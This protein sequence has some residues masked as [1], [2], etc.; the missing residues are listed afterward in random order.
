MRICCAWFIV[1]ALLPAAAIA[2]ESGVALKPDTVRAEP[3]SD[4]KAV[5]SVNKGTS[6]MILNRSGGWY[7]IKAGTD[8]GW[9]RMLSIRRGAASQASAASEIGGV[10]ALSSGRA[11]TGQIVSTTGVRGLS[12]EQ[13]K[14]AKFDVAQLKKAESFAAAIAD[15]QSFARSGAL[16]A[17]RFDYLPAPAN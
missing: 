9:V 13:L 8:Q 5:G 1:G 10:A 6:V 7:Q 16:Q 4:A 15:A 17:R 14:G 2:Q 3:Y 12:T 11:G